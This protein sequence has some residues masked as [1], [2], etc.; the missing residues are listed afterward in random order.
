MHDLN[1]INRINAEAFAES[2]QNHRRQGRWVLAKYEGLHL[3]SIETFTMQTVAQAAH[4]AAA[5]CQHGGGRSVLFTPFEV[6]A[7]A[8]LRDQSEDRPQPH[9][10]EQLAALGRRSVGDSPDV[11]LA[12]YINRKNVGAADC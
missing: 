8:P 1:V 12:D 10:L 5:D 6:S 4:D 3:V 7:P 9:S 11:T 2:I